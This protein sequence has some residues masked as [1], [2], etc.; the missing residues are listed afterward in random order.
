MDLQVS[1]CTNPKEGIRA[2]VDITAMITI[3]ETETMD[4][5]EAAEEGGEGGEVVITEVGTIDRHTGKGIGM[6]GDRSL[7]DDTYGV[8]EAGRGVLHREAP[9]MGIFHG[10]TSVA[11]ALPV[12]T[13]TDPRR[14]HS[15]LL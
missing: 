11:G 7:L 12:P 5:M 10:G 4:E 9:G 3:G 13:H 15:Q 14:L 2:V 1:Q 6:T 8:D